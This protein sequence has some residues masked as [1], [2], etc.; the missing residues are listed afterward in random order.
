MML[1]ERKGCF[2]RK[3]LLSIFKEKNCLTSSTFV[4]LFLCMHRIFKLN[5]K[6]V[7]IY[8]SNI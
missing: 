3:F 4:A 5:Y 6:D 8:F 1:I 7:D 2:F